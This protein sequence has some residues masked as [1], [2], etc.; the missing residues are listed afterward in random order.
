[1]EYLESENRQME[2]TKTW[3]EILDFI[4]DITPWLT[5]GAILWKVIDKVF[6]YYSAEREAQLRLIV[7]DEI[8][9]EIDNLSKKI[10]ELSEA[11]WALKNK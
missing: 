5:T 6:S 7:K 11:I 8:R 4:K 9:P 10:S 1:M 3:S 2:A